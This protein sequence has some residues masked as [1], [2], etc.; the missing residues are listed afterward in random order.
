MKVLFIYVD[1]TTAIGF[2]AGIGVLSAVLKRAGHQ[3]RLL[4]ISDELSYPLD[5]ERIAADVQDYQPGLICFS[6]TTNHWHAVRKVGQS[7]KE[8]F[9]I[10]I[11]VG[12]SHPTADVD[13]VIKEPWVDIVCL[14]EGDIALPELVARL[15][16][17]QPLTGVHNLV[18]KHGGEVVTEPLG[19][20]VEDLDS[21]PYDD[22]TIFY[23][24]RIIDSRS[25]WAEVI[26]TRGCPY[27]CTYCFNQPLFSQYQRGLVGHQ[28][29]VLKK[30]QYV[31]RRSVDSTIGMLKEIRDTYANIRGFTFVDDILAS[32]EVWFAD[33]ARKYVREIG[34]PYACTSHPMVFKERVA[35]MLRD[36]GCKV[37]KM[38]IESGNAD[39][40]KKVLKRNITNEFLVD[41]FDIAKR[42]GLK[43]QAF[44]M[45]GIP[46]ESI[47][48][49]MD[50]VTLNALIKPYIVWLST[51]IPYPGSELY[52][53]CRD[54]GMIDEEKWD[55]IESY[56]GDSVLREE[57]LPSLE[58][59]KLRVMFRW[60]LNAHLG[61]AAQPIYEESIKEFSGLPD[62]L[63]RSEEI[64]QRFIVRDQ[65]L[66]EYMRQ[67]DISHY[68]NKKYINVFWGREYNYDLI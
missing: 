35:E 9:A 50:T 60:H 59:R 61:N 52:H 20:F 36:S 30:K 43:P 25:G 65:E 4:H 14:G 38:G 42:Y 37:V 44:N 66:D 33:F 62:N 39:I 10:P 49:M 51:F 12:G 11:I 15:Q 57:H 48:Q 54:Q 13:A 67:R 41:V 34:L 23:Y 3:T 63:W 47:S 29:A 8:K 64:E 6:I 31:R 45:I 16:D 2:N 40:R 32:D 53:E 58:F 7:L 21:L 24:E 27:P 17:N 26:V 28:G 1:N 18:Y 46:G 5:L 55:A 68:V 56:R 22:R 19:M